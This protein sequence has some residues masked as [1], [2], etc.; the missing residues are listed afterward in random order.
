MQ[1]CVNCKTSGK[2]SFEFKDEL[3]LG[4]LKVSAFIDH[5]NDSVAECETKLV[6]CKYCGFVQMSAVPDLDSMYRQYWYRSSLNSSMVEALA[7]VIKGAYE[8]HPAIRNGFRASVMDIAAN[9]CTLLGMYPHHWFRVAVDPAS[10]LVKHSAGKCD[11]FINDYFTSKIHY[12]H[13]FDIITSIAVFYDLLEPLD[14]VKGIAQNLARDGVW[15]MQMT[16]LRC[17]LEINAFDNLCHEHYCYWTLDQ[18]MR[19]VEK[20]GL[21][22]FDVEYNDVNGRSIRTYVCNKGQ[23]PIRHNVDIALRRE[24]NIVYPGC[25]QHL[26][27]RVTHISNKVMNFLMLK[28][29]EGKRIYG[30]GASTK[31]NTLL[32][33]LGINEKL[34]DKIGEVSKEKVGKFT[35]GSNIPIV[36]E[37]EAMAENPDYILLLPWHFADNIIKRHQTYLDNGGKFILPMPVPTIVSK[38]GKMVL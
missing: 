28:K 37:A 31:G 22:V 26:D 10:N 4:V 18:F 35:A 36:D 24:K 33:V 8:R 25:L 15:I 32:Q 1:F 19:L 23:K 16:D 21:E 30:L 7:D 34:V 5:P 12:G 38:E 27:N 2:T 20:V 14:F 13:K 3:D 17:T 6:S 29:A 9:D 11:M